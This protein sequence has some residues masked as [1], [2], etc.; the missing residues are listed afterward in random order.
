MILQN[1][2]KEQTFY[3]P[4]RNL[5]F[6]EKDIEKCALG[7][8]CYSGSLNDICNHT[9]KLCNVLEAYKNYQLS[10]SS[11]SCITD[12]LVNRALGPSRNESFGKNFSKS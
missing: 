11:P 1:T 8:R 5:N 12:N 4:I 2:P 7:S 3:C 9:L 6:T 10:Q